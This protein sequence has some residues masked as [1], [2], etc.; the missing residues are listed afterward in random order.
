MSQ[1]PPL[2]EVSDLKK[3]YKLP[4]GFLGASKGA[5]YALDG[6]SFTLE[7]GE[8]LSIVGESG[9]GKSTLGLPISHQMP[10]RARP[11]PQ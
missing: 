7:K 3:H 1:M 5:V 8:T 11:L 4:G 9:C 10:L 6:V 2:L